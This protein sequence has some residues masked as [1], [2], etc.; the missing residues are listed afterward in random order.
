ME[1]QGVKIPEL[2]FLS[3][4]PSFAVV[5][6][7][8]D[9]LLILDHELK[10]R[11]RLKLGSSVSITHSIAKDDRLILFCCEDECAFFADLNTGYTEKIDMSGFPDVYFASCFIWEHECVYLITCDGEKCIK[12]DLAHKEPAEVGNTHPAAAEL[13][14]RFQTLRSLDYQAYDPESSTALFVQGGKYCLR[15]LTSREETD[16]HIPFV[17]GANE[18]RAIKQGITRYLYCKTD[19]AGDSFIRICEK[20]VQ[21]RL[22]EGEEE[23]LYPEQET[24][25]FCGGSIRRIND[26]D[27]VFLISSDDSCEDISVLEKYTF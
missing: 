13:S 23:Y 8:Y 4:T 7:G 2:Y 24:Y 10:S 18:E 22:R 20:N 19:F 1:K 26:R 21:L 6:D 27:T 12:L 11:G 15:D 5:N 3:V 9:G 16:L 14:R 17:Y 25:S